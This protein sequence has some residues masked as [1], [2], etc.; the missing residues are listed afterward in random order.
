MSMQ[1][2]QVRVSSVLEIIPRRSVS[3]PPFN[4]L[5]QLRSIFC[6]YPSTKTTLGRATTDFQVIN[7][8]GHGVLLIS[9]SSDTELCTVLILYYCLLVFLQ[10]L[11]I[12]Y[13]AESYLP[14][15]KHRCSSVALYWAL[16][17]PESVCPV[18]QITVRIPRFLFF[19][20]SKRWLTFYFSFLPYSPQISANAAFCV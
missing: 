1:T 10:E 14:S 3:S 4:P 18:F 2:K 11:A 17:F 12:L 8:D 15:L 16:V 20:A 6:P 13:L 19:Q 9:F 5:P 7:S